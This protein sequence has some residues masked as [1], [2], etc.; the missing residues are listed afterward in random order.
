MVLAEHFHDPSAGREKFIVR[1]G[2]GV[3]LTLGHFKKRLQSIGERLVRAKDPE[4]ALLRIQ[5][6]DIAQETTEHMR[7]A[8]AAIARR[9]HV[10]RVI[11]EIRHA[12]VAQQ[13]AAVGVGIG[14]HA[15]FALRGKFR[16]LRFQSALL[17]EEFL[18]P[19]AREP[20]F[21]QLQ[22]FRMSRRVRERHLVRAERAFNLLAIDHLRSRPTLGRIENDH[23]PARTSDVAVDAGVLLD[24]FDLLHRR[25]ERRGH[26][27]MHRRRLV[28]F[29]ENG[30]PAVAAK[31]LLQ[32][33][34]G[35]ASEESR[36]GNLVT[37]EMQ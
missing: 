20:V 36:V 21:Q 27:L 35:D 24:F 26:G 29:D 34:A 37:I 5:F 9:S 14:A 19:V 33:L 25:V 32:F 1:H 16:Q 15:S 30:H 17:I 3:P 18:R 23:R 6:F 13:H 2:R 28:A 12:Q 22:V 31:Q 4:I 7:V 11:A 10:N 8:D